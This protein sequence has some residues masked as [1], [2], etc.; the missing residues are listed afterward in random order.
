MSDIKSKAQ[1][2]NPNAEGRNLG[3]MVASTGNIYET[4]AII[5]R[6]ANQL[7]R[8]IKE[9]LGEKLSEFVETGETIEEITENKEQIEISRSYERLPNPAII[10]TMEFLNNELHGEYR[11]SDR[12]VG[13][14]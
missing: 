3:K 13:D 4:L 8:E 7:Q 9:E 5:S 6:R 14:F 10:A 1:A 12:E 11:H 2:I